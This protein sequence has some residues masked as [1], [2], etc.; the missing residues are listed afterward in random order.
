MNENKVG[1][2]LF[3][4]RTEQGIGQE[5][6]FRGLCSGGN[7]SKFERGNRLP[8]RLLLNAFLQ[9]LGRNA[10]KLSTLL[11][12]EEY[13]YFQWK[14]QVLAAVGQGDMETLQMLLEEPAEIMVPARNLQLQFLDQMKAIVAERVEQDIGTCISLL[15][16]A[17]ELTMPA[18][19]EQGLAGYLVS[20]EEMGI[21]LN[22]AEALGKGK[23]EQEANKLLWEIVIYV[24]QKYSDYES[25]IMIYPKA[26][27][28]LLPLL[29]EDQ[30]H[31]EGALLCK[32][33]IDLLCVQGVLYDLAELMEYY[34]RFSENFSETEEVV[35]CRKQLQALREVYQE[36]GAEHYLKE[37]VALSYSNRETYLIDEVIKRG[38]M[39]KEYTQAELSEKIDVAWETVSRI[40]SGKRTPSTRSFRAMMETLDTGLDYYNGELDTTDFLLL[41]KKQEM[42]RAISLKRWEEACGL[43]EYLKSR[44]DMDRPRNQRTLRAEENCIKFNMGQIGREEFLK[45]CEIAMDCEGERWREESFWN[46]FLTRY[47]VRILN[48]MAILYRNGHQ[49]KNSIFILE[50][51]LD[52][53]VSSKVKLEDRYKSSMTVIGNLS[54]YY[55]EVGRLEDCIKI[56]DMG[57]NLCFN[58]GRGVR[59]GKFLGNKAE[60]LNIKAGESTEIGKHYL[61]QDYYLNELMSDHK[62][63][64]YTDEYYR[65]HYE[66]NVIWY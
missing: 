6:L 22:L 53:L 62:A 25:K 2:V 47:K 60:A 13:E 41:E 40:E 11:S 57:I 37:N 49:I 5:L 42:E 26:V 8:D 20:A 66:K 7:Y 27:K 21:L 16:Q 17:V 14:K 52:Q 18:I 56:C 3:Y 32:Q 34:L 19:R 54:A 9:R 10:D 43:L 38:R 65:T 59:L 33:A 48:Y 1:E 46:Q 45:E 29:L 15:E 50:H 35:R 36:N 61:K 64:A 4:L 58:S 44:L 51:I 23:R 12:V 31:M 55:G 24:E 28:Q 30:K 63:A 39:V